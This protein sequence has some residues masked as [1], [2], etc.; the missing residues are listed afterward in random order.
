MKLLLERLSHIQCSC[1]ISEDPTAYPLLNNFG[2]E[3]AHKDCAQVALFLGFVW[4]CVFLLRRGR[5]LVGL[6][7]AIEK[8]LVN[9]RGWPALLLEV[10]SSLSVFDATALH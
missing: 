6:C 4:W 8:R 1:I 10:G 9:K 3:I 2:R 5:A 7:T